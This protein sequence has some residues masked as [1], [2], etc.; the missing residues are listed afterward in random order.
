MSEQHG[1]TTHVYEGCFLEPMIARIV[2][3]AKRADHAAQSVDRE[4]YA[5]Y[6]E[7]AFR[8]RKLARESTRVTEEEAENQPDNDWPVFGE[9]VTHG[10]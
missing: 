10:I 8:R 4:H 5:Y 6:R 2:E 1:S 3:D 7:E 9:V